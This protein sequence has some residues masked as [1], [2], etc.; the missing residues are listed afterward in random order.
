MAINDSQMYRAMIDG[1]E[2]VSRLITQYAKVEEMYLRV[3][4]PPQ[5]LQD[6]MTELYAAILAYLAKAKQY[7]GRKT[8]GMVH[9]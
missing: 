9:R 6:R 5:E 8:S 3:L 7:Y 1:V 4:S 2:L